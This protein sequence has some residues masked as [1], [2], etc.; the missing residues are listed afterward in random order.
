[1][2]T[3][4]CRRIIKKR[5]G[6]QQSTFGIIRQSPTLLTHPSTHQSNH[7]FT[8]LHDLPVTHLFT[9][10]ATQP[11]ATNS[12]SNPSTQPATHLTHP[13]S[14]SSSHCLPPSGSHSVFSLS[15]LVCRFLSSRAALLSSPR[16]VGYTV[17]T[18]TF[19]AES[20]T[21]ILRRFANCVLLFEGV[22]VH[23]TGFFKNFKKFRDSFSKVLHHK[24]T[25]YILL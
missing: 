20:L 11:L 21:D 4:I 9:H 13:A 18:S 17:Y 5:K 10:I 8:H 22:V 2:K 7:S 6:L 14:Q 24:A 25:T 15:L 19:S 12:A 23:V 3:G 16:P 1:M